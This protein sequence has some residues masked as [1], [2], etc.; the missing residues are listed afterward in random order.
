MSLPQI[1]LVFLGYEVARLLLMPSIRVGMDWLFGLRK[2]D[3]GVVHEL[4]SWPIYY[5]AVEDG[6]KPFEVRLNDRNYRRGDTVVLREYNECTDAF[7]GRSLTRRITYVLYGPELG[8][9]DGYCV[10]GMEEL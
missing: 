4:K 8:I 6:I 10:F 3:T 5:Q 7:T 2:R 1:I 9:E